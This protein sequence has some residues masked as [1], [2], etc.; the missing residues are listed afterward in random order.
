MSRARNLAP[1]FAP[2]LLLES[3]PVGY[4]HTSLLAPIERWKRSNP[5]RIFGISAA[6]SLFEGMGALARENQRKGILTDPVL[7]TLMHLSCLAA[8]LPLSLWVAA[9]SGKCVRD[10]S[11]RAA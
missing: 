1:G 11:A 3:L 9:Y 7:R 2:I 5:G 6:G 8:E 10:A 4:F